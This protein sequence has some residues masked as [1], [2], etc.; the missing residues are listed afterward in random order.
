MIQEMPRDD[1]WGSPAPNLGS[2]LK[3]EKSSFPSFFNLYVGFWAVV[4][5]VIPASPGA[6][7]LHALIEIVELHKKICLGSN[8]C[9]N[10]CEL[11]KVDPR[12]H[13]D[14]IFHEILQLAQLCRRITL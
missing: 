1:R 11:W 8:G 10:I 9:P 12:N 2:E 4:E 3:F 5:T 6:L 14:V 13:Q 7:I